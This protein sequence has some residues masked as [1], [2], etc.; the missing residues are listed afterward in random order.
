MTKSKNIGRPDIQVWP[1]LYKLISY[2]YPVRIARKSSEANPFLEVIWYNGSLMLNTRNANYSYGNLLKAFKEV[3]RAIKLDQK[4]I[5]S[6]LTLGMGVASV[7]SELIKIFPD[8][9]QDAVEYDQVVIDLYHQFFPQV[10]G[11][12]IHNTDALSFISSNNKKYDLVIVDL[13]HDLEVPQEF[14]S[15]QFTRAISNCCSDNG[16]VIFNQVVRSEKDKIV[17]NE[18]TAMFSTN[19]RKVEVFNR[20]YINHFLIGYK[21]LS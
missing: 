20:S 6:C 10:Q 16:T 11:L 12:T 9:T 2:L 21:N 18:M 19:F 4:P 5:R 8:T 17:L 15:E 1:F 3:F 7:P 14:H 13:Y